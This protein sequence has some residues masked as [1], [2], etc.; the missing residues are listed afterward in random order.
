MVYC[1]LA[2]GTTL[3]FLAVSPI[4]IKPIRLS[5]EAYYDQ[6]IVW[7]FIHITLAFATS[8]AFPLWIRRWFEPG[9]RITA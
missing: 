7:S 3:V 9:A 4:G 1:G 8:A 5:M 6:F 2:L